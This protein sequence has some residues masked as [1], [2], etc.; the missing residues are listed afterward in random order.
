MKVEVIEMT[1]TKI[2]EINTKRYTKRYTFVNLYP[3]GY[4]LLNKE[5]IPNSN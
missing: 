1:Q 2:I 5:K 3:F 4:F